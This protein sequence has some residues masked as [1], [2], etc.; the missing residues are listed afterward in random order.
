MRGAEA[1]PATESTHDWFAPLPTC[2][3]HSTC[4]W[5]TV[6]AHWLHV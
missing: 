4:V 5:F 2:V 1:F 6:T 3:V